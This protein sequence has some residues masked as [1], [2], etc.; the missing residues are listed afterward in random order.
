[1]K[2]LLMVLFKTYVQKRGDTASWFG[3]K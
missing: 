1:M 3:K 2:Y